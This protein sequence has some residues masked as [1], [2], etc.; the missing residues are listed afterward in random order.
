MVDTTSQAAYSPEELKIKGK[1]E[2]L[3]QI[4]RRY[5]NA[6]TKTQELKAAGNEAFESLETEIRASLQ[7]LKPARPKTKKKARKV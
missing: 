7:P 5:L 3:L 4:R 1:L 6:A 2:D